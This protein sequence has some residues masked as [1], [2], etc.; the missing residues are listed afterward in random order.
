LLILAVAVLAAM[1]AGV[2]VLSIT[3]SAAPASVPVVVVAPTPTA[4]VGKVVVVAK[5]DIEANSVVTT[6]MVTTASFPLDLIPGDTFT[7]P[8]EMVGATAR[9]KVFG[10][11]VL[12][13]RQF[14]ATE[15]RTGSS[16]NVPDDKLLVAFPSTDILNST[17][18]VQPGDHVDI[19]LTMPISGTAR[20]DS[21]TQTG[22]QVDG[23]RT[24]VSQTTLQNI[25]VFSTGVW[26]PPGGSDNQSPPSSASVKIITFLVD[27]Q[28]A[29]ILKYIKDSGGVIDLAVRSLNAKKINQTDPVNID[30][31]TDLYHF[32]GLPRQSP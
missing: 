9:V 32:I 7:D 14:V 26:S 24:L 2:M 21:G 17:G 13:K 23:N 6:S 3:T 22:T 28:E 1:A 30:Y 12:L 20:L 25:E 29:L 27:P 31:L 10:G 16:V 18:A 19:L 4:V 11:E 8:E 15:G 5:A